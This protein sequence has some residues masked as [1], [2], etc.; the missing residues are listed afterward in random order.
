MSTLVNSLRDKPRVSSLVCKSIEFISGF[1]GKDN[2]KFSQN[3]L[4]PY[5]QGIYLAL[6]ENAKREE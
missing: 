2:D 3:S 6:L 4:T 5:F 1:V